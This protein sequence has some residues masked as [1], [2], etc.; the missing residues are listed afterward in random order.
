MRTH[1]TYTRTFIYTTPV[2]F[3]E[4][5]APNANMKCP[6][7]ILT[8]VALTVI[9]AFAAWATAAHIPSNTRALPHVAAAIARDNGSGRQHVGGQGT[10]GVLGKR[11]TRFTWEPLIPLRRTRAYYEQMIQHR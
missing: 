3:V 10:A 2:T 7:P 11:R 6:L 5:S 8:L 1:P 9:G 4:I